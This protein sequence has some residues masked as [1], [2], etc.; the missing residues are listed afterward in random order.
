MVN[1][2]SFVVFMQLSTHAHILNQPEGG[3]LTNQREVVSS[4]KGGGVCQVAFC[5]IPSI[6][7]GLLSTVASKSPR[8]LHALPTLMLLIAMIKRS[9]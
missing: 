7:T 6:S 5:I 1:K 3:H 8:E 9:S 4:K 2:H